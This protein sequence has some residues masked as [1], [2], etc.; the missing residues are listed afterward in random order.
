MN[1]NNLFIT[2]YKNLESNQDCTSLLNTLESVNLSKKE[3]KSYISL[4]LRNIIQNYNSDNNL[5]CIDN[6]VSSYPLMNRDYW[7]CISYYNNIKKYDKAH[8]IMLQYIKSI[9]TYDIDIMIQNNMFLFIK[10]WEGFPVQASIEA[11]T[12]DYTMLKKYNFDISSMISIYNKK[13]PTNFINIYSI[14]IQD[15]DVLIDGANISHQ[16]SSFDYNELK[17]VVKLLEMQNLKPKIILHERHNIK[18]IFLQ[19]YIIKTPK[20]NYDDNFLLYGMFQYNKMVVSNDLF[21]DHMI[22]MNSMIKCFINMMTIQYIDKKL[23][24]PQYSKCIQVIH[25][26]IYIPTMDGFYLMKG[27]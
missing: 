4:K 9:S 19:K 11:N 25:N 6:I 24:I 3:M 13:I 2:I 18:D 1:H 20:N 23:I 12:Y 16:A 14:L 7:L 10:M 27:S 15:A 26:S 22:G 8:D 5:D 21:R 17:I